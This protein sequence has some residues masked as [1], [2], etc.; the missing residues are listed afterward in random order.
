MNQSLKRP[1]SIIPRPSIYCM[2]GHIGQNGRC[3]QRGP[4]QT[5]SAKDAKYGFGRRVPV[6]SP[7]RWASKGGT[8]RSLRLGGA[9][10]RF[11]PTNQRRRPPCGIQTRQR[12]GDAPTVLST[13][14]RR[15]AGRRAVPSTW[16]N[17][18]QAG[19]RMCARIGRASLSMRPDPR[20]LL[21]DVDP[22]SADIGRFIE[23][24]DS[25]AVEAANR[26]SSTPSAISAKARGGSLRPG[27]VLR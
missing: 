1:R 3:R 16:S 13:L 5:R 24:M 8:A 11:R 10:R 19:I 9:R 2:F 7:S 18:A 25:G 26:R 23:G 21:A 15:C 14:P 27:P 6:P 17:R 20:V 12:P 22:A 4:L